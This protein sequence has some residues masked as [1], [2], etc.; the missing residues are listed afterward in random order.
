METLL[1][2]I[3]T[4]KK[5]TDETQ[6]E[7]DEINKKY[8]DDTEKEIGLAGRKKHEI[9][10]TFEQRSQ[11][12][13][14]GTWEVKGP[15]RTMQIMWRGLT[16]VKEGLMIRLDPVYLNVLASPDRDRL[17][18]DTNQEGD[19]IREPRKT[20]QQWMR[21][22]LEMKMKVARRRLPGKKRRKRRRQRKRQ[23]RRKI[24]R[25]RR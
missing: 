3:S 17:E 15:P 16:A 13:Q 2:Y 10:K 20:I 19:R 18:R 11:K 5:K 12:T 21:R 24:R 1:D 14:M 4:R 25:M 6:E 9:T 23:R 22:T 7:R 8:L